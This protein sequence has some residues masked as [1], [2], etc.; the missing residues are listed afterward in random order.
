MR[1]DNTMNHQMTYSQAKLI[2]TNPHS[3]E[4]SKLQEAAVWMLAYMDASNEDLV[5]AT[6][7]LERLKS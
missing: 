4:S 7:A 5:E 2:I 1:Y 6:F 3:Y